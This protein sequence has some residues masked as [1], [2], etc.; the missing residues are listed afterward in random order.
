[1]IPKKERQVISWKL[2]TVK[3][4]QCWLQ[5][6]YQSYSNRISKVAP[7]IAKEDLTGDVKG[8]YIG[9]NIRLI[10]DSMR[11]TEL[12]SIPGLGIFTDFKK[13]IRNPW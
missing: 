9:Q 6:Y 13:S 11:V 12:E 8:R 2:E 4:T 7:T 1:M 5:N 10:M 3:L